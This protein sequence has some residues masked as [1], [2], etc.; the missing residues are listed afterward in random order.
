MA[1]AHVLVPLDSNAEG[2]TPIRPNRPTVRRAA[3]PYGTERKCHDG[4]AKA[5]D[6]HERHRGRCFGFWGLSRFYVSLPV[7]LAPRPHVHVAHK[8]TTVTLR[9]DSFTPTGRTAKL[10]LARKGHALRICESLLCGDRCQCRVRIS[11]G[12]PYKHEED[13]GQRV[14]GQ[15]LGKNTAKGTAR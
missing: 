7:A 5:E 12:I 6:Q 15:E 3:L 2:Y 14:N 13:T 11:Q 10:R 9:P 1:G 4:S 8:P